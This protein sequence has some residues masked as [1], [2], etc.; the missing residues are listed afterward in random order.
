VLAHLHVGLERSHVVKYQRYE[1]FF[2][3]IL[4]STVSIPSYFSVIISCIK[5][6]RIETNHCYRCFCLSVT[7]LWW[8]KTA[9][10]I[11]VLFE[12]KTLEGQ[13]NIVLDGGPNPPRR[14]GGGS[15]LDAAFA[16]L[17][18]L[19]V[20]SEQRFNVPLDTL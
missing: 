10:R 9:K 17:L 12:V 11:D 2:F 13:K 18:W 6:M 20:V 16:K 8:A 15:A 14:K 3:E 1:L 19:L 4:F 5:C 7:W